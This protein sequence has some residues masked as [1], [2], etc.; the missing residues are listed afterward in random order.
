FNLFLMLVVDLLHEFELGV[1]KAIFS[2][3]LH[4]L[5]SLNES[6][7]HEL[8]RRYR[9]VPTFGRDTI[10]RFSKNCSE[11]KRMTTHDFEDLLQ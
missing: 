2:H 7:L 8:D 9:L 3:L 11:M 10:Q 4:I 6:Q 1:W 5:D